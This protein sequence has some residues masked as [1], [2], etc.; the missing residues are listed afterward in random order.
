MTLPH[1]LIVDDDEILASLLQITLEVE[2][3]EV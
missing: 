1:I 2:G 3:Y